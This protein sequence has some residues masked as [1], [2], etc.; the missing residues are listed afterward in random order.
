MTSVKCTLQPTEADLINP[1]DF[2]ITQPQPA[3][4]PCAQQLRVVL[5]TGHIQQ[6][7]IEQ[8]VAGDRGWNGDPI[9]PILYGAITATGWRGWMQTI[10]GASWL[11]A[12]P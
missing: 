12:N 1:G 8:G 7:N 4:A 11:V 9:N 10:A 5:P 3:L 2:L 6:I